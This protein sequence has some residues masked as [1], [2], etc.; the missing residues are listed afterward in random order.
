MAYNPN[1]PKGQATMANSAPVVLSS[2]QSSVPVAA[3]L[4]AET[5]KVI[6]VTRTADGSGNLLT[7]TTN[8]LDINIKSGNPTSITANAGTNLNTS[9]LALESGGNLATLAG[10]VGS[11]KVNVNISSGSIANTSFASTI[12]DGA[13]VTLGAKADAKSTATDTTAVTIMQVLKE[14]S[15]ME[16]NPA[17]RAVTFTGSGDVATQTTLAL[18][19]A[20]TDNI[21][22]LGQAL[23]AASVPV[24]LPSATITTLTPPAAITGFATEAGHL[25][26]IDTSTARIPAQGQ[27]LAAASLP[28]VLTAA[29]MTTLT[30]LTSVAVP[31]TV[32]SVVGSGT[33]AT[34][35][36]VTIATDSTGVLSVDDNGGSLTV[37]GAFYQATQPV[38]IASAQV[39]SGAIASGAVASGAIVDGANVALGTTTV[40]RSTATDTTSVAVI[41]LLKEISYMEQNPASRAVTNTGT[42]AVQ[43]TPVT[44]ADTFLLGAVNIKEI[45]AVTPLMGNGTTGTGSQRVTIASDNTAFSVNAAATLAAET[46]KVIGTARIIGNAGAVFDAANNG[47]IPANVLNMGAQAVSSENSAA[48]TAHQVQL[49]ADLVGKQIVLPYANPENFTSGATAAITD[50]TNTSVIASAGGSLRN[51]I[52]NIFVTNSHATVGTLV[53]I[54]D[55]ATTVLYRGYAA[56]AGGG[57]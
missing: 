32:L 19:K 37:D 28:V 36:R 53:E 24:I 41:P 39:A 30:P 31:N 7:S 10:T 45:T 35:Q 38:S 8:A 29:Q 56:A 6:G 11:S 50:T 27:A 13:S 23:A 22:A 54:R 52:T 57:F 55:G 14:I 33:E 42:F 48:T 17:S 16:Q 1:L 49:V 25:A 4:G 12:A 21:P 26:T 47:T 44:Q 43:A 51:Y 40:A 46:T 3:T 34:A 2:D 5:T 18:I 9:A 15:Y 20:K